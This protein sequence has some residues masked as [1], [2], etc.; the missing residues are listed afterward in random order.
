MLP[1]LVDQWLA[2][3]QTIPTREQVACVL[4][5]ARRCEHIAGK[6]FE[7]QKL[8]S[9]HRDYVSALDRWL[10]GQASDKDLEKAARPLDRRLNREIE[11][12]PDLP[13][14]MAAHALLDTEAIAL[15]FSPEMLDEILRAAVFFS[16]AAF[17]G[18]RDVPVEV[19]TD[20]LSP[21]EL[22]FI[23]EWWHECKRTFSALGS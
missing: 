8:G 6:W 14:A 17:T 22:N 19:D 1:E 9:A 18:S 21:G 7:T 11:N 3:L 4:I 16:A 12:E 15:G 5:A 10:A 13:G 2:K 23:Q 20:R